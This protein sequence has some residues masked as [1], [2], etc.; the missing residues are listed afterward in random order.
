MAFIKNLCT[1]ALVYFVISML[2][3]T[4]AIFQNLGNNDIYIL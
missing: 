1:P 2:G 4:I 3:L